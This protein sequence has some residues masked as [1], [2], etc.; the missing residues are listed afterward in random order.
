MFY[1]ALIG[2]AIV[3]ILTLP[4]LVSKYLKIRGLKKEIDELKR[5]TLEVEKQQE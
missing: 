1:S 4:K 5:K 3:A 2:A